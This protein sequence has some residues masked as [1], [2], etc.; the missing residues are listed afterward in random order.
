MAS[1]PKL[2]VAA[3][4]VGVLTSLAVSLMIYNY[5]LA[6]ENLLA[7]REIA[8]VALLLACG[9]AGMSALVTWVAFITWLRGDV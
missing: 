8:G 4:G 1:T 7:G 5:L 2:L 3:A 6:L 9:A